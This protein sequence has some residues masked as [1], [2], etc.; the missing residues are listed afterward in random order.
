MENK[1]KEHP[2][3]AW[4]LGPKAEHGSEWAEIIQYVFQDYIHWRRNYFPADQSIVDRSNRREHE[5]WFDKLNSNIDQILNHLKA[6]YPFYSPRYLAHM[7]SEQSLPSVIGYFAGMLYNPNNVTDEAAPITVKLELEVGQMVSEMLGFDPLKSW[8]HITSGGTIANL[9]ALWAARIST[10]TP[11]II[12]EF[13]LKNEI[14]FKIKL[15]KN[16][17]LEDIRN[18]HPLTLLQLIPNESIFMP[19]KLSRYLI[20]DLRRPETI[21]KKFNEFFISS[22]LNINENGLHYI[23]EKYKIEP[24]IYVSEAAHYS[25]KKIAN[26]LGFGHKSIQYVPVDSHFRIDIEQLKSMLFRLKENQI[27]FGVIGIVGTTEEGAIDPIDKI[28]RLRKEFEKERNRSFWFHIDAAWGGYL[29]SILHQKDKNDQYISLDTK[30]RSDEEI[31]HSYVAVKNKVEEIIL[32]RKKVTIEWNNPNLFNSIL[33]MYEADSIT[34]DP[35]KLGYI[36]YPSGIISFRNGLVTELLTQEA[37][38][39]STKKSGFSAVDE[40]IIRNNVGPYILEGSKP[41][42][43]AAATWLAHKSIPLDNDN[44][45]KIIRTSL[46]NAR[47]LYT[48]IA[49]HK[50][51]YKKFEIELFGEFIED[52]PAF[53]FVPLFQPDSN[54]VCYIALPCFWSGGKLTRRD[55]S[56]KNINLL[57]EKIYEAFSL[58]S[59][60]DKIKMPYGQEYFISRTVIEKNSYWAT[61]IKNLLNSLKIEIGEYNKYGIFVLRSTVMN[62]WYFEA[63]RSG[64]KIDY[65]FDFVKKLHFETKKIILS[66]KT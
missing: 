52:H 65:L 50:R 36:P 54:I 58:S 41:G 35:H 64:N 53:Y 55:T 34:I 4:F 33:Y 37:P 8:T 44:H 38:Y 26:L 15:P 12:Q 39:I 17:D 60:Q 1:D 61:S 7:L 57:N 16:N 21:I 48:Y 18:I 49:H 29:R 24:I 56:L 28:S 59:T 3:A 23:F 47:K 9:E 62:P 2:L 19:R 20:D 32:L 14:N 31:F 40:P 51:L 5:A 22:K 25:F 11:I 46:L 66:M 42:A 10:I 45:G 30:N 43:A 63:S 6:H 27:V 13:C